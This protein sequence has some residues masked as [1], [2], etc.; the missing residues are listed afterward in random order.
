[1]RDRLQPPVKDEHA[2]HP[3]AEC[4]R[5]TL[6]A[7]VAALAAGDDTRVRG[8]ESVHLPPDVAGQIRAFLA[9]YGETLAELPEQA[10]RSSFAQWMGAHWDVVLDLWTEEAGASDLVLTLRVT[11]DGAGYRFEV[12]SLHVP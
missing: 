6:R 4:W 12:E 5:P 3:I 8:L 2:S 10:W 7:I 9:D 1:M 11:E